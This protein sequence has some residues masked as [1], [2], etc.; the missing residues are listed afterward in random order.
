MNELPEGERGSC[1]LFEGNSS[2]KHEVS[3]AMMETYD[4]TDEED[5]EEYIKGAS[6]GPGAYNYDTGM[7]SKRKAFSLFISKASRFQE[8]K[9]EQLAAKDSSPPHRKPK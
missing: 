7:L 8:T 5:E 3:R 1:S 6:P 9:K 4:E 2:A